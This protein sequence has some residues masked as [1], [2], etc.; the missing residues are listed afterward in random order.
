VDPPGIGLTGCLPIRI[1]TEPPCASYP[2]TG[3][4]VFAVPQFPL[5]IEGAVIAG[6]APA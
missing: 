1:F 2:G 5:G 3:G 6:P 4:F